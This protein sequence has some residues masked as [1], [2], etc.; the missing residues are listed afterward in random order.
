MNW[1]AVVLRKKF[2]LVTNN[3]RL[4]LETSWSS[5]SPPWRCCRRRQ[6]RSPQTGNRSSSCS[7]RGAGRTCSTPA[8][9]KDLRH[10]GG[11]EEK[12]KATNQGGV[13][14]DINHLLLADLA[15][16]KPTGTGNWP[17]DEW[18]WGLWSPIYKVR[19][20]NLRSW[21][22]GWWK[23]L[24]HRTCRPWLS[25][26]HPV[27]RWQQAPQPQLRGRKNQTRPFSSCLSTQLFVRSL[28]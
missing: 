11:E 22:G 4:Y 14:G 1:F 10:E 7:G 27:P 17:E 21:W 9:Q 24:T 13:S 16:R 26:K 19:L 18:Y 25:H 15:S 28:T 6:G 23:K 20:L 3:W 8:I 12:K 2:H 5:S